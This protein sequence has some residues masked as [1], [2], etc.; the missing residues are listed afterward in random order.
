MSAL[1]H[2][3]R[4]LGS[5]IVVMALLAPLAPALAQADE[6]F[7]L[8]GRY[9]RNHVIVYFEAVKLKHTL[10]RDSSAIIAPPIAEGFFS[11]VQVSP[12]YVDRFRKPGMERFKI[13]DRY[14]LLLGD[15]SVATVTLTKLVGCETDE[16][17]GNDSYIGALARIESADTTLL[18]RK[19]FAL[20]RLESFRIEPA[21]AAASRLEMEIR[22]VDSA[23]TAR[24][25]QVIQR[26]LDTDTAY[27]L[28]VR[29]MSK[30]TPVSIDRV[31][32]FALADGSARQFVK[33]TF[34]TGEVCR[35]DAFVKPEPVAR[36]LAHGMSY[37]LNNA[38]GAALV[39]VLDL[40][41][42]RTGLIFEGFTGDGH[43]VRLVEYVDGVSLHR[44]RILQCISA[45]E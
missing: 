42:G 40:G 17:V 20:R 27:T 4:A 3:L 6:R 28:G 15:G 10:P 1:N 43:E 36:V 19:Y 45:G 14:D 7:W 8:A 30:L 38:A 41:R 12:A 34:A 44:L 35:V 31:Q 18:A 32:S 24:I 33:A 21:R 9:D 13:G 26:A 23:F 22:P 25:A 16:D 37:C 39:N 29:R 11:P 2:R 5:V